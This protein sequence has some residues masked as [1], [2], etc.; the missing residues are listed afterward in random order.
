MIT[1]SIMNISLVP[2]ETVSTMHQMRFVNFNN[3]SFEENND[4]K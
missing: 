1:V 2:N 3:K 4:G